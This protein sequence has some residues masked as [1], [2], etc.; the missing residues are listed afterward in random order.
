MLDDVLVDPEFGTGVVKI[1]PDKDTTKFEMTLAGDEGTIKLKGED[2]KSGQEWLEVLAGKHREINKTDF[3]TKEG[4][5][6]Q[7]ISTLE[8][9]TLPLPF[10]RTARASLSHLASSALGA[11]SDAR[12]FVLLPMA[13][14]AGLAAI[15]RDL[16][17]GAT[18]QRGTPTLFLAEAVD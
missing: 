12:V 13:T 15:V 1:T 14:L 16:A 2:S 8:S 9:T 17:L 18:A 11:T 7:K 10:A 3:P 6:Q 5:I 4:I